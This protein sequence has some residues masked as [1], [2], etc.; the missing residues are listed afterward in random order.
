MSLYR[1]LYVS[2]SCLPSDRATAIVSSIVEVSRVR[3]ARENINGALL[4]TGKHFAQVLE[5]KREAVCRLMSDIEGDPGHR[6]IEIV[7]QGEVARSMFERW[8]MAYCGPVT[9][10]ERLI[11]DVRGASN[12]P[13]RSRF[14]VAALEEFI[15]RFV[16]TSAT[17]PMA[18]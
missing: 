1:L 7:H 16:L 15:H 17:A 12:D 13:F 6:D 18:S 5:G 11:A 9:Y 2:Q 3:N 4:F 8:A 10:V 14:R